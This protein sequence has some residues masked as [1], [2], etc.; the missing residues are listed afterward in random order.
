M[1]YLRDEGALERKEIELE[2]ALSDRRGLE[3]ALRK[4][5]V[6]PENTLSNG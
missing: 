6:R 2:S 5:I 1:H 3:N 4:K